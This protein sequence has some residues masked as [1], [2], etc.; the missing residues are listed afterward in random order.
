MHLSSCGC[1][2]LIYTYLNFKLDIVSFI[3]KKKKEIDVQ[4]SVRSL[5]LW[6]CAIVILSQC[7]I[8]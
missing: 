6:S 3:K 8:R 7:D 4:C 5:V 2:L 1:I